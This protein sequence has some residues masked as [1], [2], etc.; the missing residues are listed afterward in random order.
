MKTLLKE[1]LH[2]PDLA[3]T[4]ISISRLDYANC[5]VIFKGGMCTIKNS[6]GCTMAT[7]PPST[8][9]YWLPLL[10]DMSEVDHANIASIKI[11]INKAH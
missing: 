9:L 3:F 8:R 1:T 10:I 2:I 4:L 7:V 6:T 11:D 5:S